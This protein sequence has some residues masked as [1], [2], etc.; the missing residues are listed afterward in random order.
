M[1]GP[2]IADYS[3]SEFELEAIYSPYFS[4]FDNKRYFTSCSTLS[5]AISCAL[6]YQEDIK[7]CL[8][9]Y[10]QNTPKIRYEQQ[11]A[12][13]VR[14]ESKGERGHLNSGDSG[15]LTRVSG[16][17]LLSNNL[18]ECLA[19]A[20]SQCAITHSQSTSM[21]YT[22]RYTS[23]VFSALEKAKQEPFNHAAIKEE[24]LSHFKDIPIKK[25]LDFYC[26]DGFHQFNVEDTMHRVI[27][28]IAHSNSFEQCIRN[29]VFIGGSVSVNAAICAGVA[30]VIWGVEQEM[31]EDFWAYSQNDPNEYAKIIVPTICVSYL[32]SPH[33]SL[34]FQRN[35]NL[36]DFITRLI[37]SPGL[38]FVS[39]VNR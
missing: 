23:A 26:M 19:T 15:A 22:H 11:F 13:W 32:Y 38:T 21:L 24:F 31:V 37:E 1:L 30:E 14:Q 20:S 9:N 39:N 16:V 28:I 33:R 27:N 8:I 18:Q 36:L 6:M 35:K 34:F 17:T 5:T 12:A 25:S 3:A 29:S 2:I 7:E 10:A 4:L